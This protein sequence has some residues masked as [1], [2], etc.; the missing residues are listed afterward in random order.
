[1]LFVETLRVCKVD[2][3]S[4]TIDILRKL[5]VDLLKKLHRLCRVDFPIRSGDA[6]QKVRVVGIVKHGLFEEADGLLGD[7]QF[8][9]VRADPV[10]DGKVA[11]IQAI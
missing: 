8:D 2:Q 3:S 10:D 11:R 7:L 6:Q 5:L 4:K 9:E 1:M